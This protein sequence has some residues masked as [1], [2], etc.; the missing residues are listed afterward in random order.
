MTDTSRNTN[1][2]RL[3]RCRNWCFTLNNHTKDDIDTLTQQFS[4]KKSVYVFQEEK[5]ENGTRHLQGLVCFPNAI[6]QKSIKQIMPR[7]HLEVCKNKI[8]SIQYCSKEETRDGNIFTNMDLSK[9]KI[10]KPNKKNTELEII[11]LNWEQKIERQYGYE[12]VEKF[13][14]LI[15]DMGFT[16]QEAEQELFND[17]LYE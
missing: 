17:S 14:M 2:G 11:K 9:D 6:S 4:V 13:W 12:A 1:R 5:G 8:A 15:L 16:A 10:I 3:V 7:A